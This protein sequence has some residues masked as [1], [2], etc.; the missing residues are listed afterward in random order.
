MTTTLHYGTQSSLELKLPAGVLVAECGQPG[1]PATSDPAIAVAQALDAPLDYPPIRQSAVPG[2]KVVLALGEGV[3]RA[4]EIVRA[5]VD[6]ILEAGVA[7]DDISLLRGRPDWQTDPAAP[8]ALLADRSDRV[9]LL[10]H[11]PLDR[12]RLSY[13][14]AS[15]E[16]KPIY[17]NRAL[18]EADL[19]IPIGCLRPEASPAYLGVYSDI[20]P[21]F[22]D[23]KTIQRHRSPIASESPVQL[24]RFRREVEEVGWLLGL[25]YLLQVVPGV[26]DELLAVLA[27]RSSAVAR[28]GSQRCRQAWEFQVPRR[29]SLVLAAIS[30]PASQQT[31]AN[32]AR[33]LMSAARLVEEGG[34]IALVTELDQPLGPALEALRGAEKPDVV[35][36]HITHDRPSDTLVSVQLA[37]ALE[38]GRVYMLSRLDESLVED[39]GMAPIS[40]PKQLSRLAARY[41][42]CIV[43]ANAQ[44][45]LAK[46]EN[47]PEPRSESE[48]LESL[49]E[50]A[51][52]E[53]E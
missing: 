10:V 42:S 41:P 33:A 50:D 28:A 51:R 31:W 2:D 18:A 5:L 39:L 37:H 14:A 48:A 12:N 13:L 43:L 23:A 44:Y 24:R 38:R 29:A 11:D 20:F 40:D 17:I 32:V 45:A 49:L 52:E 22:S 3:P 8:L 46:A 7:I 53:F 1:G 4:A 30:G 19:S 26:P 21:A 27:G 36:R 6:R 15:A 34:A 25:H 9:K 35:L 47:E 16:G